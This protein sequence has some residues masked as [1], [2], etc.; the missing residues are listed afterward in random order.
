MSDRLD[1]FPLPK[2]PSRQTMRIP[3]SKSITNRALMLAAL[4][5]DS[6]PIRITA[7]YSRSEDTEVMIEA[8][9]SGFIVAVENPLAKSNFVSV[10]RG[11][12]SLSPLRRRTCLS[13]TPAP[14]CA[15]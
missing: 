11:E 7:A 15:S 5:G 9:T 8:L 10:Y 6:F 13:P 2:P 14:V 12:G 1:I 4:A 3:G